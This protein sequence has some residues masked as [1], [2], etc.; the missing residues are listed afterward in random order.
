MAFRPS[1]H[2]DV[3]QS[4]FMMNGGNRELRN[5]HVNA[6]HDDDDTKALKDFFWKSITYFLKNNSLLP[7][8]KQNMI[9]KQTN[10]YM[11]GKRGSFKASNIYLY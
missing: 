6:I 2:V 10:K 11:N 5:S 7:E 4:K 3:I 9:K 8:N 1:L